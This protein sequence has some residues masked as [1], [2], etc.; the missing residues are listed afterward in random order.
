M[1]KL[2]K[3]IVVALSSFL[4]I[5]SAN[6]APFVSKTKKVSK[7]EISFNLPAKLEVEMPTKTGPKGLKVYS[8][9]DQRNRPNRSMSVMVFKLDD[10]Q[11]KM[12]MDKVAHDFA[13]GIVKAYAK[14]HRAP[15]LEHQRN[16]GVHAALVKNNKFQVSV[17]NL[18]HLYTGV[19]TIAGKQY[20]YGF[21]ISA[22]NPR[23]M[24]EMTKMLGDVQLQ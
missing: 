12:N 19:Y 5:N 4:L 1:I 3:T 22:S 7:P 9:M 20:I 2:T 24:N 6:A 23:Y 21:V 18:P 17:L 11:L 15:Y 16:A 8:F 14:E 10:A 13:S